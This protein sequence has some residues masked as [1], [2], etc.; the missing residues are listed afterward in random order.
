MPRPKNNRPVQYSLQPQY[1]P[2]SKRDLRSFFS[3]IFFRD[4]EIRKIYSI[5][6]ADF[7][8]SR[9]TCSLYMAYCFLLFECKEVLQRSPTSLVTHLVEQITEQ[10]EKYHSNFLIK[11]QYKPS[12]KRK[13]WNRISNPAYRMDNSHSLRLVSGRERV[14]RIVPCQFEN[15]DAHIINESFI[16]NER[17]HVHLQNIQRLHEYFLE[18]PSDD[19]NVSLNVTNN[20]INQNQSDNDSHTTNNVPGND[21]LVEAS[22]DLVNHETSNPTQV[23]F[24]DT[25]VNDDDSDKT[26]DVESQEKFPI[27]D[28]SPSQ[29]LLANEDVLDTG[30]KPDTILVRALTDMSDDLFSNSSSC[31]KKKQRQTLV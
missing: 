2:I 4:K 24:R 20:E 25:D 28:S 1:S 5:K 15:F 17:T 19:N 21:N 8:M 3:G 31:T 12:N 16:L 30:S 14:N 18:N 27:S 22:E 10:I 13:R 11:R 7:V 23:Q 29:I 9:N 26:S 6:I